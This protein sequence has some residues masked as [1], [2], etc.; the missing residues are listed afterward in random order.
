MK[1]VSPEVR[2]SCVIVRR[3]G[4]DIGSI[5]LITVRDIGPLGVQ[6]E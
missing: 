2:V 4:G 5:Q 3:N 6:S 1:S